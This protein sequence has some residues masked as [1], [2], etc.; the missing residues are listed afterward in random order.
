MNR[1]SPW[2][3]PVVAPG[4]IDPELVA[5]PAPPMGK[6]L[7]A[8]ALM[9]LTVVMAAGVVSALRPDVSYFFSPSRE[10][11]LGEILDVAPGALRSNSYVHLAGNPMMSAR[12][13]YR[14]LLLGTEYVVFPLAGQRNVLVEMPA[15]LAA[16]PERMTSRDFT[17]RL[18]TI[19]DLGARFSSVRKHLVT[20][21]GLPVSGETFVLRV[22]QPPGAY[23]W[24]PLLALL[25][26][27][28]VGLN[29]FL[30]VRWFRPLPV[31]D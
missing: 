11:D 28:I 9:A 3:E 25:C 4:A 20:M 10:Q 19:S 29:L 27:G 16:H 1:P 21:M 18:V 12:V 8:M 7:V 13:S 23:A 15:S 6:R 2:I 30:F 5:L 22:G 14:R 17:G 31:R 26:L 24:A